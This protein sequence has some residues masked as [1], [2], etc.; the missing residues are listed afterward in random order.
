MGYWKD[1]MIQQEDQG[2]TFVDDDL[3][4]CAKCFED[5]AIQAFIQDKATEP[6]CSY[7]GRRSKKPIAVPMND[8]LALIGESLHHE[9]ADPIEENAREDGEW[10]IEPR[11]TSDVF[12]G[13]D[14]ITENMDVFDEIVSAFGG[15]AWVD[16][17]LWSCRMVTRSG[18]AGRISQ[19][20]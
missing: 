2:W 13:L 6:K 18:T 7:C 8:V 12:A 19:E 3:A 20:W 17:P 10:V 4:V 11:D 15:S 9:Y 5:D 16:K 14:P 1:R